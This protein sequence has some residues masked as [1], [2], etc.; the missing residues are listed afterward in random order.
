VKVVLD[1]RVYEGLPT[2]V[3]R[4][5]NGLWNAVRSERPGTLL[6]AVHRRP[7]RSPL[8]SG[9]TSI[10]TAER[11]P[12]LVWGASVPE[13]EGRRFGANWLHSP[14]N[15]GGPPRSGVPIVT[16]VHDILPLQLPPTLITAEEGVRWRESRRAS[17][18]ASDLVITPSESAARGVSST[19]RLKRA[20]VVVPH[21]STLQSFAGP[22]R[23]G[24]PFVYV[25]GFDRRKGLDL[26]LSVIV[27]RVREGRPLKPLVLVG[28]PSSLGEPFDGLLESARAA[29]LVRTTG[30]IDDAALAELLRDATA[31]IYPSLWEGFGLPVLEAMSVGCPVVTTRGTSLPEVGGDAVEY[32]DPGDTTA[33]ATVLERLG[34]DHA[35]G[36]SL[37]ARGLAR[38]HEFSWSRSARRFLSAL[39]EAGRG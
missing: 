6:R 36:R 11:L 26:L 34:I 35:L 25:G 19:F 32:V 33:F 17:I 37:S 3:V 2:G 8:P 24:G 27:G 5:T 4:A 30:W 39:D 10:Q 22:W 38:S 13:L 14:W 16:T 15:G 7:L 31:L 18:E 1:A 20:P 29:G 28:E 23:G 9:A 12:N 21:G